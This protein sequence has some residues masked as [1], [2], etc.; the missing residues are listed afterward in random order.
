M[1]LLHVNH[2]AGLIGLKT[3]GPHFIYGSSSKVI[4]SL[5]KLLV[6]KPPAL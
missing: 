5:T 2:H 3:F 1:Y 4:T 6:A